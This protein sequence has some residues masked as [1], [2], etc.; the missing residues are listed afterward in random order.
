MTGPLSD[1][2]P[3]VDIERA[4]VR[5]PGRDVTILTYGGMLP[6][7]LDAADVLAGDGVDAEVVDLR[8]LR[9]LDVET[10]VASV[11]RTHRAVVVDEGW[12]SGGISA[13]LTSRIVEEDFWELDAP[14]ARVCTAE[15][16]IPYAQHLEAAALPS[17]ERIVAAV[18]GTIAHG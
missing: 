4:V 14:V 1:P 10:I 11:A 2:P 15:V 16:P 12:R 18:Q 7:T 3:A 8:V 9:P 17:V 5:R 13:E 6:R